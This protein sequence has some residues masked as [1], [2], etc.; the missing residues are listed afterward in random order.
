MPIA[1]KTSRKWNPADRWKLPSA[2]QKMKVIAIIILLA[3]FCRGALA[4]DQATPSPTP[5]YLFRHA[6]PGALR[7]QEEIERRRELEAQAK[8]DRRSDVAAQAEA[9][10]AA[11]VRE[12]AQREVEAEARAQAANATPHATSDL[13]R[14]MG[15]SAQEIA[16]QKAREQSLKPEV[17]ET[18][19]VTSQ[20]GQQSEQSRPTANSGTAEDHL[21]RSHAEK[22]TSPS[23]APDSGS[24]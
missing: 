23:P 12:H 5:V 11:R 15:F 7:R 3:C 9:K 16:A 19:D 13:M 21:T 2:R 6:R 8:A 17:K 20:A 14:R 1:W 18:T 22:S 24:H 10:A 4:D